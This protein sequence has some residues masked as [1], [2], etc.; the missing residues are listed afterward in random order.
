VAPDAA[1]APTAQPVAASDATLDHKFKV[2]QGKYNAEVPRLLS[3]VEEARAQLAESQRLNQQ[4]QQQLQAPPQAPQRREDTFQPLVT[5]KE[6]QDFGDDLVD[7]IGRRAQEAVLPAVRQLLQSELQPLK[8]TVARSAQ[9]E[10][11]LRQE[12][13]Y[14]MLNE[15]VPGWDVVNNSVEFLAWLEQVDVFSGQSRRNSLATAWNAGDAPRVVGI[16]EAFKREDASTSTSAPA[17]RVP[18]E[19]LIAPGSPRGGNEAAPGSSRGRIWSENEIKDFYDRVRRRR[20]PDAE[21]AETSA[22]I[23]RAVQEGRVKPDRTD[24]HMNQ[25]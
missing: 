20:V 9:S 24:I 19:T 13:I 23:A 4:L 10:S 12:R 6:R 16:F 5:D 3:I 8:Q 18:A 11:E 25:R 2:L 14:R 22:E 15:R 7:M 1:P 21:Y 17:P